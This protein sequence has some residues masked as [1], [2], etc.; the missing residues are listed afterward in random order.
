MPEQRYLCPE[1][2][3]R[4]KTDWRYCYP[5]WRFKSAR[6]IHSI[7]DHPK[8]WSFFTFR[9]CKPSVFNGLR[10]PASLG[11]FSENGSKS[12]LEHTYGKPPRLAT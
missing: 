11:E 7:K 2:R 1:S 10:A 5:D 3:Y 4:L 6:N 8:G 9:T 12:S